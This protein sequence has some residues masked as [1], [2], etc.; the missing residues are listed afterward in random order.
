MNET[1]RAEGI[2]VAFSTV[3]R[4]KGA[5]GK[6]VGYAYF[7]VDGQF[8]RCIKAIVKSDLGVARVNSVET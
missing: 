8:I 6:L 2:W 3:N 4:S 5:S 1:L 7:I